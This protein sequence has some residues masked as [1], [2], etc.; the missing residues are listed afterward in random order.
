M[1][2]VTIAEAQGFCWGVRRALD[3]VNR[4]DSLSIFGDLIHNKQVV[5]ELEKNDKKVVQDIIADEKHPIVITAHGTNVS[6]IVKIQALKKDLID[7]T[8]PLVSAIYRAGKKLQNEGYQILIIG[9]RQHVEVKGIASR[10][11][12]PII[13]NNEEELN[14]SE[15]PDKIGIICQSTFSSTKFERM[16]NIIKSRS[17]EVKTQNTICSPTR[18]RQEAAEKLAKQVEVMVVIG[19]FHS[20]NTKKLVELTQQYVDS[21]HIETAEQLNPGWFNNK[22]EIGITAGASTA[23]WVIKEVYDIILSL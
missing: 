17:K 16:V 7:T 22:T 19:G 1:K 3:I 12:H 4:H 11:H 8:C 21:Y 23:D 9:D 6:N 18:K 14:N 5:A 13:I 2:N 20:S 15:L 10:M